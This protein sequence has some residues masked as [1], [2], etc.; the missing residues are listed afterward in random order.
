MKEKLRAEK[1]MIDK[2]IIRLRKEAEDYIET[3]DKIEDK[4]EIWVKYVHNPTDIDS[5]VCGVNNGLREFLGINSGEVERHRVF[6]AEDM[7]EMV[8]D[9]LS[10]NYM[11]REEFEEIVEDIMEVGNFTYDW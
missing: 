5:F 7:Y 3:L 4:F 8:E 6:F 11:N 10:D 1:L 2:K 9:A